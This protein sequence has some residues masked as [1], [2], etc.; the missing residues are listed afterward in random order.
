MLQPFLPLSLLCFT[1]RSSACRGE[2]LQRP[3]HGLLSFFSMKNHQC[4]SVGWMTAVW[5][6][7]HL[8]LSSQI[9][10][11]I[12][13]QKI[14]SRAHCDGPELCIHAICEIAKVA[15]FTSNF[16]SLGTLGSIFNCTVSSTEASLCLFNI[17]KMLKTMIALSAALN[18][19]MYCRRS[20]DC[21]GGCGNSGSLIGHFDQNFKLYFLLN[22]ILLDLRDGSGCFLR[23]GLRLLTALLRLNLPP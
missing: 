11:P 17:C 3:G 19:S 4:D 8:Y 12:I 18:I 21:C 22:W 7:T 10:R 15:P 6:G 9:T 16:N 14:N 1:K 5:S 23:P 20:Y 13:P 2:S